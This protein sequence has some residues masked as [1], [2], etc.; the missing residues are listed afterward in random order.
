MAVRYGRLMKLPLPA[1]LGLSLFASE[2]LLALW[3]RSRAGTT[4]KDAKSLRV[5]WIV[6]G[7]SIFLSLRAT[8]QWQEAMLPHPR[9]WR[10]LGLIIFA[11]GLLLRWY[12]IA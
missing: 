4:S 10:L 8:T 6:I 11:F 2:V 12:A 5:L 3:K 1:I 9:A 7:V